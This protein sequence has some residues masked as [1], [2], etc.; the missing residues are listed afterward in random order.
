MRL[1]KFM[2]LVAAAGLNMTLDNGGDVTVFSPTDQALGNIPPKYMAS[3]RNEPRKMK[4]LLQY[5]MVPGKLEESTLIGDTNLDTLANM[6]L[7]IK[8]TV[9][10]DGVKLDKASLQNHG[11]E[12]RNAV[13]HRVDKV[14]IPPDNSLMDELMGDPNLSEFW[15]MMDSSGVSEELIPFGSYTVLAPT[16]NALS[17]LDQ[18]HLAK[19]K[20]NRERLKQFVLR[21]VILRTVLKCAVPEDGTY[22]IKSMQGDETHFTFDWKDRLVVNKHS[23]AVSDDI[24]TSNGILYKIDHVIPCS[25]E[26][27]M[28]TRRGQ[29]LS[30]HRYRRR[31]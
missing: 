28:R 2:E 27:L 18:R 15:Q 3:L 7:K 9:L 25:C 11:R 12:C 23:R 29:Y 24:L 8:V 19:M 16:N 20:A 14:L 1:S 26:K 4:E 22:N 17:K 21:H 10:R 31:Y 13:I 5:H 6:A 30:A